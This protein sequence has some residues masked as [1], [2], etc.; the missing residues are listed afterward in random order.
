MPNGYKILVPELLKFIVV[1]DVIFDEITYKISRHEL[2]MIRIGNNTDK[3]DGTFAPVARISTFRSIIAFA[4]QNKL[5][6]HQMDVKT[7]FLNRKQL[8]ENIY[9]RVP[10]GVTKKT[11]GVFIGKQ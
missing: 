9:R 4:N 10:D 11:S 3:N 5:L 2:D 1:R 7:A 6:I 8:K